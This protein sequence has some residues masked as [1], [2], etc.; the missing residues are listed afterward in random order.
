VHDL[1]E[2]IFNSAYREAGARCW[3]IDPAA[4]QARGSLRAYLDSV[5]PAAYST[6]TC[7]DRSIWWEFV[8]PRPPTALVATCFRGGSPKALLNSAGAVAVGGIAGIHDAQCDW[9][10]G[11]LRYLRALDLRSR[12]VS[13]AKQLMK[14]EI[15]QLNTLMAEYATFAEHG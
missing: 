10:A 13:H 12:I 8:M 11:F 6:R 5:D 1:D 4:A 3:L 9:T 2:R 7:L 14:L 15:G